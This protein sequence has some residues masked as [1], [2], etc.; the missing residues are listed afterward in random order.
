[1]QCITYLYRK[2]WEIILPKVT[3]I[4]PV[5]LYNLMLLINLAVVLTDPEHSIELVTLQGFLSTEKK[6]G[7]SQFREVTSTDKSEQ[8]F[9]FISQSITSPPI[10]QFFTYQIREIA[11]TMGWYYK[12]SSVC[13]RYFLTACGTREESK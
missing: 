4:K 3:L 12:L 8:S 1:M 6:E 13:L 9:L 7:S 5:I 2:F 10:E 11:V